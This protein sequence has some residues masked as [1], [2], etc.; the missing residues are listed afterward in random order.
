M[1]LLMNLKM[2]CFLMKSCLN[3]MNFLMKNQ[4][5]SCH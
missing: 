5:T 1:N 4:M 2:S 3:L